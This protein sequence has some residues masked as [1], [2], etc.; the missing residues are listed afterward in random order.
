MENINFEGVNLA[1]LLPRIPDSVKNGLPFGIVKMDLTG[2]ILEYNMAEG[3]LTGVDPKWAIG[4]NFFNEV[5]LCTKTAA[6]YGRFVEGVKKGFLNTVFEFVFDHQQEATKVKVHMFTLPDSL[7]KKTVMLLVK[8]SNQPVVIDAISET[9]AAKAFIKEHSPPEITQTQRHAWQAADLAAQRDQEAARRLIEDEHYK[10]AEQYSKPKGRVFADL[11]K[12]YFTLYGA[13]VSPRTCKAYQTANTKFLDYIGHGIRV[14]QITTEKWREYRLF[15]ASDDPATGRKKISNRSID[16]HTNAVG[17]VLKMHMGEMHPLRQQLLV[18]RKQKQLAKGK[19]FTS[20][21]LTRVFDPVRLNTTAHPTDVW[22]NLLGLFTGARLNELFQLRL[23]DVRIVNGIRV[24]D[25]Q[26]EIV[27][28]SLKN[29]ASRRL[30]PVHQ[31]LIDLGF[32][33]YLNDVRA[34]P[35]STDIT[36]IFPFLTKYEQ[37]YGDVPS[38]RFTALLK[39]LDI[40]Q[41]RIKVFHSFRHTLNQRLKFEGVSTEYRSLFLGH[42]NDDVN[43]MIYGD[44]TPVQVVAAKVLPALNFPEIQW[45]HFKL[46]R[47]AIRSALV[48]MTKV[49]TPKKKETPKT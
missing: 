30:V 23:A 10:I 21:E 5:A 35:D 24:L 40:Y 3:E 38:Q 6:F 26:D 42:E 11:V 45:S 49:S 29:Q 12:E 4:K 34:L 17:V 25:L 8:R 14:D 19:S 9:K 20:E 18:K 44:K 33:D 22:G 15:L 37:G 46:D 27:G 13:T 1:E 31:Q 39:E 48:K 2:N 43:S 41:P 7:G 36:L 47:A 32:L 28:N 16:N